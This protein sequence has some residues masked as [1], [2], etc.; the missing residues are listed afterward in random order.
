M[1]VEGICPAKHM[2]KEVGSNAKVEETLDFTVIEFNKDAKKIV[3][4][5]SR[6]LRG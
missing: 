6:T 5:H 4:S 3:V 2:K 1:G